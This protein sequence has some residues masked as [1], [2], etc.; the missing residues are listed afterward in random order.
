M[1]QKQL[2]R[3]FYAFLL[4]CLIL[5]WVW[6]LSGQTTTVFPMVRERMDFTARAGQVNFQTAFT[7][8]SNY[9]E[10]YRNGLL[11]RAGATA[12]YIGA[13]IIGAYRVTFNPNPSGPVPATGDYVTLFYYR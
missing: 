6:V 4:L 12:D 11:Q 9:V 7:V 2:T 5:T 10:V 3:L 13:P 8:R 1:N